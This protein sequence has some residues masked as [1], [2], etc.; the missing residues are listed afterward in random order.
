M[1]D[2]HTYAKYGILDGSLTKLLAF[3]KV[4]KA[5]QKSKSGFAGYF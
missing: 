5:S 1:R 3:F 2:F 4:W